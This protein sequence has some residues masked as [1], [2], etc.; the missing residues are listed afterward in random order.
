MLNDRAIKNAIREAKPGVTVDLRDAG[1][2]GAGKLVLRIRATPEGRTSASWYAFAKR[3]GKRS[4]LKLGDYPALSLAE[5]RRK[6]H[7]EASPAI[8]EGKTIGR[9]RASR[10]GATIRSLFEAYVE[11]LVAAGQPGAGSARYVLLGS[12]V[13]GK[14]LGGMA[15]ALGPDRPAAEITDEQIVAVLSEIDSRGPALANNARAAAHAAFNWAI[16]GRLSFFGTTKARD[17]GLKT[18][19]VANIPNNTG[20]SRPGERYLNPAELRT[21]WTWLWEYRVRSLL[22][23]ALL[24]RITTGGRAVNLL[25]ITTDVYDPKGRSLFWKKT[26]SG[27]PLAVPVGRH[28]AAILDALTP[29]PTGLYFPNWNDP[30]RP[31]TTTGMLSVVVTFLAEHPGLASFAPQHLRRTTKTLWGH[32]GIGKD[33]RDALMAHGKGDDVSARHYDRWSRWDEKV[34]AVKVWDDY[35]DKVA[36]GEIVDFGESNVIQLRTARK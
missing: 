19:P 1:H 10:D 27:Q 36:S 16:R 8:Q 18:N 2:R 28:T 22:A 17:W 11:H 4:T 26:K 14:P 12:T 31:A 23:S 9:Q 24:L 13:P 32:A 5:A 15:Q 33:I 29:A 3:H 34:E 6:F 7:A 20:A 21:F 25:R 30:T 35:L